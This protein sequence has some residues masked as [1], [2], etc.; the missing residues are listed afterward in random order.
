MLGPLT[1]TYC[2]LSF[3]FLFQMP[4]GKEISYLNIEGREKTNTYDMY[5]PTYLPKVP[6]EDKN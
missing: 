1:W 5:L 3:F 4:G 6:T 2:S